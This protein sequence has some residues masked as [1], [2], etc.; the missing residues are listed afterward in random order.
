MVDAY[1]ARPRSLDDVIA[2]GT[3][4]AGHAEIVLMNVYELMKRRVFAEETPLQANPE[5]WAAF[6]EQRPEFISF[7][8]TARA[9]L[10]TYSEILRMYQ[11][12]SSQAEYGARPGELDGVRQDKH[13]QIDERRRCITAVREFSAKFSAM[14]AVL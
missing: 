7:F 13:V 9:A 11:H 5:V 1:E 12:V 8:E 4:A 3:E 14:L 10:E 6:Q 2:A